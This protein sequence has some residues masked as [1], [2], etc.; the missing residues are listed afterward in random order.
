VDIRDRARARWLEEYADTRMGDVL[1]WRLFNEVAIK[2]AV[3]GENGDRALVDKTLVEDLPS[4]LDYLESESVDDGFRFGELSIADIAIACFFRN[5]S[6]ARFQIDATRWPGA[7]AWIADTLATP[8]FE[9][10]AKIENAIAR[11]PIP[12]QREA[13]QA[14]GAPISSETYGAPTPRR[15]VMPT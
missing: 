10:L 6:M 5:A 11:I 1:I 2:P 12:Q 7:A 15:G 8:A 3:W 4:I 14:L 13:L 9:K